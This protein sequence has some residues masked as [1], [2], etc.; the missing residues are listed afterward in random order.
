[1][2]DNLFLA[3]QYLTFYRARTTILVASLTLIV[4]LPAG[5]D[6][7][8]RTSAEQLQ[9]R[10]STT[11]LILGAKGSQLDLV[12]NALYFET[13]PPTP[14]ELGE[15]TRVNQT[16]YADSI[17]LHTRFHVDRWPLVG[18]TLDYFEFRN[19][20]VAEGATI[21]ILGDC[22]VGATVAK[23]MKLKPGD[24]VG[25]K[26]EGFVNLAGT[27]P[28]EMRVTGILEATGTPDDRAVFIDLKT[29]WVIEGLGHGHQDVAEA[30][31]DELI[32]EQDATNISV[33]P[34]IFQYNRITTDNIQSFHFH[35][36]ESDFP[37]SSLLI[38]PPDGRSSDLL[39]GQYLGKDERVQ[40][41][42]PQD[43][44]DGLLDTVLKV[45]TFIIAGAFLVGLS[46]LL[47]FTLVIVLSLRLRQR[48]LQT[49]AKIGCSRIRILSFVFCE[50]SMVIGIALL[51]ATCGVLGLQLLEDQAVR[52][53]ILTAA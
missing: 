38:L 17:P 7:V 36:D 29:A 9:N 37:I 19:L 2:L 50:L 45:R 21:S 34:K 6:V 15:S 51:L 40:V 32:L 46:T 11:P 14:I 3:W 43:H 41:L 12:L 52:W 28:L 8:V 26:A 35:G 22:V 49:L 39:R 33:S 31:D 24:Y 5:L 30:N 16:G 53:L 47:T 13:D 18:T 20:K 48:E 10:A 1:M 23:A 4:F 27:Y 44:I 42:V 25:S